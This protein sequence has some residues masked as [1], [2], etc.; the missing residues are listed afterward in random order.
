MKNKKGTQNLF[1]KPEERNGMVDY[2]KKLHIISGKFHEVVS[3]M[4]G[5]K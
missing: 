5:I 1:R 3:L 2:F 4:R